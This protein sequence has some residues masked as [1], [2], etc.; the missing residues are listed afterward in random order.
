MFLWVTLAT[1]RRR[2]DDGYFITGDYGRIA[3]GKIYVMGRDN[4]VVVGENGENVY[5]AEILAN[6]NKIEE[7]VAKV[8]A[9]VKDDGLLHFVLYVSDDAREKIPALLE[10]Y[11]ENAIKKDRIDDYELTSSA[12]IKFK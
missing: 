9:T 1:R 4:D 11:N 6:L 8:T 7:L 3:D 5:L 10:K 2:A 12:Q